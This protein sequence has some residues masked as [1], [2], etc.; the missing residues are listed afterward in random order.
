MVNHTRSLSGIDDATSGPR[1]RQKRL[2]QANSIAQKIQTFQ[3]TNPTIPLVVIGDLNAYQF[4]DGYVDVVGRMRGSFVDADDLVMD[5]NDYVDPDLTNQV[6]SLPMGEQ[7]S[8][9]FDGN[10]QVLDHALTSTVANPFV[11]GFEYGHGNAG[12]PELL[13]DDDMTALRSSDHDGFAL[14]LMTDFD[15]DSVPDDVDNCPTTPNA[16]QADADSD[17]FG[18][19]CDNC[20]MTP[21]PDQADGDSDGFGDVCDNCAMSANPDQADLDSDGVGD[22]CDNCAM[23]PNPD[24]A[25]ADSDGVGDVCDNCPVTP[26]PSQS[27]GDG[28]GI[29]DLCDDCVDGSAPVFAVTSQDE[30]SAEGTVEDCSGIEELVLGPGSSNVELMILS[31]GP[32]DPLWTWRITVIDPLQ[33][34]TAE[35]LGTDGE[36][37]PLTG[38][39]ELTFGA[40][41]T[42]LEIP[43]LD[44]TGMT[45]LIALLALSGLYL[46]RRRA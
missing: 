33:P 38:D 9:N 44:P 28:D 27:D 24:Q 3:T 34:A 21:N 7:H 26:N 19:V 2:E 18:D 30:T 43:T 35:L 15:A 41:Q 13:I 8:F 46:R 31:G 11:R 12:A 17:G 22:A 32:G 29:G 37:I 36:P 23:T 10:G 20:A 16:D 39:L 40:S 42:L 5:P 6:L 4:S 1:V 45:I 14:F 25:D